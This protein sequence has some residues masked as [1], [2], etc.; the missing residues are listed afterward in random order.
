[1]KNFTIK[2][3]KEKLS[4]QEIQKQMNF[5]KFISSYT[6]PVKGWLSG[7]T[8]L[9]T[10]VA[11]AAVVLVVAGYFI[12]NVA[13]KEKTVEILFVNPPI[14]FLDIRTEN[15]VVN[16]NQD[17]TIVHST[18]SMITIPS[19]AFVDADGK[20]VKG[21][22]EI[23]YRE[24]HDPIDIMLSG[25]PMNYDSA[26]TT[27]QFESAGMFEITATQDGKRVNLKPSKSLTVNMISHTNN[28]N[29]YNIYSLDTVK[30]KW[31]YVS[32]NTAKN[33]SCIQAFEDRVGVNDN[34]AKAEMKAF[35]AANKPLIPQKS[36][37]GKEN[38]IIDFSK[39][40][41]PELAVFSGLKF[42][43]TE[44]KYNAS[45]S[46]KTWEE[47]LV[48]RANDNE[49]YI[50]TFTAGKE[51]HSFTVL[52]V[53]D[54]KDYETTMKIFANLQKKYE[55]RLAEKKRIVAKA[56][57]SLYKINVKFERVAGRSDLNSKFNSFIND[58]YGEASKDLLAYRTFAISKL[59]VW[60]SDK[61]F[62]FFAK[63]RRKYSATFL[64]EDNQ[65]LVLKNVYLI[66]DGINSMYLIPK[67][68]FGVFPFSA[69]DVDVMVGIT[70]E[71]QVVY[72][73]GQELKAV[74]G[75]GRNIVFKMN[76]PNESV[77]SSAQLKALLKM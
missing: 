22:V 75:K 18:G 58:N 50:V 13:K 53:V 29:D 40:E 26:G 14:E 63:M 70:E 7:G 67:D 8:K 2:K 44:K 47:V 28:A 41:F 34:K 20:D 21:K 30:K 23:H 11:S 5:D 72:L 68:H 9:Y 69:E 66:R 42:Q 54:E 3:D 12:L 4:D 37:P 59:G 39:D 6:P 55:M 71:N 27:Y 36:D 48:E 17:T 10:L 49:H 62:P 77:V 52:P 74:E 15:Y 65:T 31:E 56:S 32:E 45:L 38:F 24:F 43:P 51:S 61:P 1:M 16:T 57:D 19:S 35:V 76:K 46:Q 64:S 73:K 33:N 25:I 60:N